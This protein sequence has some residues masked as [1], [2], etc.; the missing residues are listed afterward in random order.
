MSTSLL[1]HLR[2]NAAAYCA[3]LLGLLVTAGATS[4]VQRGVDLR[5]EQLFEDAVADGT[6]ALQLR[7][8]MYQAMLLGTRGVFSGSQEVERREFRAYTESLEVSQ[9]FPGIQ[10]IGFA[11]WLRGDALAEHEARMRAEGLP[12]Y[13]VRPRLER[14]YHAVIAMVEPFDARNARA[15]GYDMLSESVR[16][17]AIQR[18]LETGLPAATG[19]VRLVS[20]LEGDRDVQ[21]GFVLYVPLFEKPEPTT[22]EERHA[23]IQ[24]FVFGAFRMRDLV[25]GMRFPGFRSTIDLAIYD[26]AEAHEHDLLF[27]SHTEHPSLQ[28]RVLRSQLTLSVAGAP[29]TLVFTTRPAF[30]EGTRSSHPTTVA[31]GGLLMSLLVFLVTRSQ[32][33]ARAS[34]ERASAEQQRLASEAQAAVRIRDEF[35][36]V[37]AHELRTPLTSLKLQLQLLFRQ[38]H[39]K[40]PLDL[41]RLERGVETCERQMTRL[42]KLVDNLLDVSRLSSGRMELQLESLEL[43]ELVR[44]LA[45]RFEMEA[46]TVNVRLEVDAPAPMT[47]RWDRLRLEQVITNLLSNALKYGHGAPVDVHVRGD[48]HEARLEVRDR[49]IGIA[50]EDAERVFDRFERAVSSRHYGGLGLGL[51]ITRQLV[52]AH[53]GHIFLESHPGEGTTFVVVLP[54]A[55]PDAGAAKPPRPPDPP[56]P[57]L[58]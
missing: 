34:A 46:Q 31:L 12:E 18:A 22:S 50:A 10:C 39:Q 5:R 48:E 19:K 30:F 23:R 37:A 57:P 14:P 24:G 36:S 45:R 33:N 55:G 43:G 56:G 15:L 21:A 53:G 16:H 44:E 8:D 13:R 20:E 11:E 1:A 27:A 42:T 28:E 51:F 54:R 41:S 35:L 47:G 58:H 6:V 52:E 49:G 40:E 7:M 4:Y 2:R 3:L 26:G 9:R 29:W 25:E 38:I 32:V 17:A